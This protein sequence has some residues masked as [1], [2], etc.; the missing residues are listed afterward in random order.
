MPSDTA[1]SWQLEIQAGDV[2][3]V[4]VAAPLNR[5]LSL[6]IQDPDGE[7]VAASNEHPAGQV[8]T[9]TQLLLDEAGT[10]R[11]IVRETQQRA[12][13]YH[14]LA[15]DQVSA[16]LLFSGVLDFGVAENDQLNQFTDNFWFFRGESNMSVDI[17]VS[18]AE[19]DRDI[20]FKVY[21]PSG[22]LL[23]DSYGP[24]GWIDNGLNGET[25][26]LLDFALPGPGLY[27]V[28]VGESSF[29]PA[30]FSITVAQ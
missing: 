1:H 19:N 10:Y 20:L 25:E 9:I 4:S 16:A 29:E 5:D 18:P 23:T 22:E 8:E 11:I 7:T 15:L 14:I 28:H 27:A 6:E 21:G 24:E 12:S 2:I 17:T 3:T 26:E 13:E 30:G